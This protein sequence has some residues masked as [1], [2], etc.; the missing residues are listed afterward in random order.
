MVGVGNSVRRFRRWL[1]VQIMPSDSED[2]DNTDGKSP[3]A[4]SD[5]ESDA[6][7]CGVCDSDPDNTA[8]LAEQPHNVYDLD[9]LDTNSPLSG[10][11]WS[12][13]RTSLFQEPNAETKIDGPTTSSS[14]PDKVEATKSRPSY[15]ELPPQNVDS[16]SWA[17]RI[18]LYCAPRFTE[19][20]I[21]K[22]SNAVVYLHCAGCGEDHAAGYFSVRQRQ[23]PPT[24]RLCIGRE[25][26]VRLCEHR[27]VRWGEF[28]P[29]FR[30]KEATQW[31]WCLRIECKHPKCIPLLPCGHLTRSS[32]SILRERSEGI[33]VLW[34]SHYRN[35]EL[36]GEKGPEE[37]L[38]SAMA[39]RHGGF[40]KP[41]SVLCPVSRLGEVFEK[42]PGTDL[43]NGCKCY[44][45]GNSKSP[46]Q[47]CRR[48]RSF[49]L[50]DCRVGFLNRPGSG[51]P[52]ALVEGYVGLDVRKED[53]LNRAQLVNPGKG[54]FSMIHPDSYNSEDGEIRWCSD[55][56]CKSY[57]LAGEPH[58]RSVPEDDWH[59]RRP[60]CPPCL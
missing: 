2:S 43:N 7:S 44:E 58:L 25:G 47:P 14:E 55:I 12:N 24:Q 38:H 31:P 10:N 20:D 53:P 49:F 21:Q 5:A 45:Y 17:D 18:R 39:R 27:V 3:D 59:L 41:G 30:Q 46:T 57:L 52:C 42:D 34:Y 9:N 16:I 6:Q 4:E 1:A 19:L 60:C 54:W 29:F 36:Q 28:E 33:V 56:E 15:E 23:L 22:D 50:Y 37:R 40:A 51:G 26:F 11:P 48:D 35:D 32:L 13:A 8:E